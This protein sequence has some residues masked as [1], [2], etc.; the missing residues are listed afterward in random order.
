[1][2]LQA[3]Q[4]P[5]CLAG[6]TK[7]PP[8][9]STSSTTPLRRQVGTLNLDLLSCSWPRSHGTCRWRQDWDHAHAASFD[10]FAASAFLCQQCADGSGRVENRSCYRAASLGLSGSGTA[11]LVSL[12]DYAGSELVIGP[13]SHS[14]FLDNRV[15]HVRSGRRSRFNHLT[16]AIGFFDRCCGHTTDAKTMADLAGADAT[17]STKGEDRSPEDPL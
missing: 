7:Q 4:S 15:G 10:V 11:C 17:D 13:W 3:C 2:P 14:G 8:P 5:S 6:W 1:M 12:C 16:H 9:A